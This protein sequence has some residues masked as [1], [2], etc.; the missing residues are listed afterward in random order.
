[1][2]ASTP[3]VHPLA[4]PVVA[5]VGGDGVMPV[6]AQL[7][8]G[9]PLQFEQPWG[10]LLLLLLVP[11]V[12][13]ARRFW[14]A[15]SPAKAWGALCL[16]SFVIALLA[17]A[18]SHPTFVKRG[19]G[20]SVTVIAD[21][22][23]SIPQRLR[24]QSEK[25]LNKV[26]ETKKPDDRVG[27]IVVAADAEILSRPETNAIVPEALAYHG[28]AAATDLASALRLGLSIAPKDTANVIL[29]VSDGN[30]N[31]GNLLKEA[32]AAAANGIPVHVLPLEYEHTNEVVFEQVQAPTRVRLGSTQDVRMFVRTQAAVRARIMLSENGKPIDLDPDS[33]GDGL[34]V[35]L[36]A[37]PN[38]VNVPISFDELAVQRFEASIEPIG[39][40]VDAISENNRATAVS[41]VTGGGKILIIDPGGESDTLA[42]A[43]RD[44]GLVVEIVAPSA[45]NDPASTFAGYDA[46]IFAN[47]ARWEV[48]LETDRAL[49]AAVHD[50]GIGFMML[51][52]PN[53]FGA[54]G[55]ID[56]E[57]AKVLPIK[58]DPPASR[59]MVRG[60]LALIVHACEWPTANF[61]AQ[62]VAIAAIQA[63]SRLDLIGIITFAG[64]G[65]NG[66]HYPLTEA[67][68]KTAA[69][70]AA[71]SMV[72]GDMQDFESSVSLAYQGLIKT[73]AGQKHIIIISDG[74]PQPP[75]QQTLLNCKNAKIT[76]TTVMLSGGIGHGTA[77]DYKNMKD[78]AIFTGGR[79]W[80]VKNPKQLP[81]IFTKEA[82]VVTRSLISEGDYR[83]VVTLALS[84]P[85]KGVTAVPP[86][87]GYIVS[88]PKQGLAQSTIMVSAKEGQDPL[89][90]YW[91]YGVGRSIAFNSDAT[92]RWGN[93]WV[94]WSE[95]RAFWE[96]AVR[97]LM[98]PASPSNVAMRVRLEGETAVVEMEA[99]GEDSGGFINFLKSEATVITPDVDVKPL[100]LQQIGPGRYRAEFPVE[101]GGSYLVNA[102]VPVTREG[103]TQMASVQAV[104]NVAYPKEFQTVR[105]NGALL[106]KVAE[107][108]GGRVLTMGD[109]EAANVFDRTNLPMPAS[110]KR[111]WDLMAYIAAALLIFDVAV[112]RLA[113]ERGV[114]QRIGERIFGRTEKVGEATVA[115]WKSARQKAG[116]TAGVAGGGAAG[117]SG[118]QAGPPAGTPEE[119]RAR[120][121]AAKA[122]AGTRFDE[123]E[124][125]E[126]IDVAGEAAGQIGERA[127]RSKTPNAGQPDGPAKE[128]D[129]GMSRL[130]KAK[131]R[132]QSDTHSEG[133]TKPN[134][135][136]QSDGKSDSGTGGRS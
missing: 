18:V 9:S 1:M 102:T 31:R 115:A 62:Q 127:P 85:L 63:L 50:M 51:G 25:W 98:R 32:E 96:Q 14:R 129:E 107:L 122:A 37:G 94:A 40:N 16:R 53:S 42:K 26:G 58:L 41:Y 45:L 74:D 39:E 15:I 43:L 55:W 64:M 82:T 123:S 20:L 35:D 2:M 57:T 75:S 81:Q 109:P 67:G 117:G 13:I 17:I 114:L 21:R 118:G 78:T 113:V 48:N 91:N 71:K 11:T 111:V 84:G 88:V 52:G 73:T 131:R 30:E 34:E 8:D 59:Q 99:V 120:A 110:A 133:Q 108:T 136:G 72:V 27:T 87:K 90:S 125:G 61:W 7:M 5:P 80:E 100:D 103:E 33:P 4:N 49:H 38:L 95:Y 36:K 93:S 6:V 112:R 89:F 101:S 124:S 29:L 97:W 56:T 68:D 104:V 79:F 77:N 86:I 23:A 69:I 44:G 54:G 66:W 126:S 132:A 121:E 46:I 135:D 76:I 106:R 128:G 65:G 22:S 92:T 19:K 3:M 116:G 119:R 47:V 70:A 60:A 10:L 12:I 24:D 105:D 83:P 130:L 134:S 28:D